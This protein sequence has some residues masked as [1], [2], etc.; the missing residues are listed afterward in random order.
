VHRAKRA[1]STLL[2]IALS[3]AMLGYLGY[4]AYHD[5]QFYALAAGPKNWL[6]LAAAVPVGL[7]AVTITILRWHMLVRTLGLEFT[8]REALRAGFI[9]YLVNLMPFGL[10]GGDSLKAVML[11][12]RQPRRKTEAVATVLVDRVLGLYALLLLAALGSFFLPIG[13][14]AGLSADDRA[15]VQRLSWFIQAAVIAGSAG[16]AVMLVPGVTESKLWD[17]LE[18]AP[19]V[20]RVLHKLVQ[21]MRTYRQAVHKLLMAIGMS[22]IVHM[23]YVS[24]VAILGIGLQVPPDNRPALGMHFIIVPLAMISGALPIGAFEVTLNVLYHSVAPAGSPPNLGFLIALCYRLIQILIG[25]IGLG[26]W[27]TGRTEVRELIHEAEEQPPSEE[28]SGEQTTAASTNGQ[29]GNRQ[30]EKWVAE[31]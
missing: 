31:K 14:L 4:R 20:G 22:L 6:M 19:L 17:K 7:A 15:L 21:A 26:Y 5:K 10:V 12:H 2:K 8:V 16:L 27:L 23:L 25:S 18:H 9:S 28:L 13:Q 3:A 11:I 30:T 24:L 1:I 29:A